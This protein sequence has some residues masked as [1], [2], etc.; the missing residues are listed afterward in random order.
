MAQ[1]DNE[2][3]KELKAAVVTGFKNIQNTV[4]KL[5]RGKCDYDYVEIMACP[6]GII[7]F[8]HSF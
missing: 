6:S 7:I 1:C 5:K 2:D 3:G 8:L 4:N